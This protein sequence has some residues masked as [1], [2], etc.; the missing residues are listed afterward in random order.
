MNKIARSNR[1]KNVLGVQ[2][3]R[4][5]AWQ[6]RDGLNEKAFKRLGLGQSVSNQRLLEQLEAENAQLRDTVMKL[7]LQIQALRDAPPSAV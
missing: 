1:G 7:M 5:R 3:A 4:G 6:P 2:L